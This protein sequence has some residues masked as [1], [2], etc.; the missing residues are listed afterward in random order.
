M[1]HK[2]DSLSE[3]YSQGTTPVRELVA[4]ALVDPNLDY[5]IDQHKDGWL[6]NSGKFARTLARVL[7]TI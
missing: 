6:G 1:T 3:L 4:A 5:W 7:Q 2:L